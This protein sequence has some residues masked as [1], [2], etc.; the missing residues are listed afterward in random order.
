MVNTYS[1][2]KKIEKRAN[3]DMFLAGIIM[4]VTIIV[5]CLV[6]KLVS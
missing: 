6:E 2:D 1:R 4:P 5:Y 3:R